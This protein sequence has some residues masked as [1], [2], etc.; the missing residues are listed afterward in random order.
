MADFQIG[1]AGIGLLL[2]LLALR[3]PIGFA[4]FGVAVIGLSLAKGV[5]VAVSLV[6]IEPFHFAAHWSFSAIPM[7]I[8]MGCIAQ[9]TRLARELFHAARLWLINVPGGLAVA[10]NLSCAGFAAASGSSLATAATMGRITI[11]E[12]LNANYEKGLASGVVASAGTV[13]NMIPPSITFII[14]GIFAEVSITKLFLAGILPGLLTVFIYT[15]MIVV[16][17]TLNPSLAPKVNLTVTWD[18]RFKSLLPIWPIFLL[19]TCLLV[20]FAHGI[21]TATEG[22]AFGAMVIFIITLFQGRMSIEVFK[23][24]IL[25]TLVSTTSL[26]WIAIGAIMFTRF[27]AITGTTEAIA[28]LAVIWVGGELS[29]VFFAFIIFLILGMFLDPLGIL[30]LTL[31]IMLPI[32]RE[33]EMNLIWIGVLVVKF[34]EI[35]LLTPPVGMNVYAI[36]NV[37]GD[38]ISLG[39]IFKGTFWFLG[40]EIIIVALLI[41]APQISLFLPNISG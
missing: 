7:F 27:L 20:G 36:K 18:M 4:L 41:F 33:F 29:A 35:G 19:F 21:I 30:L 28:D 25:D 14:F 23:K 1:F 31:P 13:G 17:C 5:G 15:V 24:S 6:Q 9:H 10:A 16:R 34:I 39:T 3:V 37:V 12:M 40:C 11:P 8:L 26:L 32:F 2:L 38:K 22:G